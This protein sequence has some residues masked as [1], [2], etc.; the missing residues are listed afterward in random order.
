MWLSQGP[1][2]L[3]ACWQLQFFTII[4][5]Q[6]DWEGRVVVIRCPLVKGAPIRYY[7]E[8]VMNFR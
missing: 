2:G 5:N 1:Y 7:G 4:E 3:I 8:I 6:F